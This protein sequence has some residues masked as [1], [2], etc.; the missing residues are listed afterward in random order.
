MKF[1]RITNIRS[2]GSIIFI[3]GTHNGTLFHYVITKE[4][5][6]NFESLKKEIFKGGVIEILELKKIILKNKNTIESITSG[7][8]VTNPYFFP[9]NYP[10]TIEDKAL[11]YQFSTLEYTTNLNSFNTLNNRFKLLK[12]IRTFFENE[13]ALEVDIPVLEPSFGGALAKPFVTTSNYNKKNYYLRV[14]HEFPLKRLIIAG[15]PQVF[16]LGPA[17]RNEDL[18][19]RH[20]FEFMELEYYTTSKTF[21]E[22]KKLV[23]KL[24][25]DCYYFI[26]KTYQYKGFDLREDWPSYNPWEIGASPVYHVDNAEANPLAKEN[27]QFESYIDGVEFTNSY[28]EQND[29]EALKKKANLN[30]LDDSFV[31]DLSL[32]MAPTVGLGVG[33][34]RMIMFILHKEFIRDVQVFPKI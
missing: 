18:G 31:K 26:N 11:K 12:K 1:V 4:H 23:E 8:V 32:G 15:F 21:K 30:I 5:T 27:K 7:K 19:K 3:D 14:A 25:C 34:D 28:Q 10:Q 20:A 29:S 6:L 22:V 16:H 17:F 24:F 9:K 2:H 33:I 13:G